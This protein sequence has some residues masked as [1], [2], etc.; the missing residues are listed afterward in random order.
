MRALRVRRDVAE[1]VDREHRRRDLRP[2]D[3][4]V[5]NVDAHE[6]RRLERRPELLDRHTGSEMRG[7]RREDVARVKGARDVGQAVAL[8]DEL[9]RDV[10]LELLRREDQQAVVGADEHA[11]VNGAHGDRAAFAADARIDDREVHAD[12]HVDGRVAQHERALEHRL[13]LDAVRD[14]DHARVRRDAARSRRGRCRR[15]R[16]A[17]RSPSGR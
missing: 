9:V 11:P 6:L 5:R 8:V 14:V 12:R 2:A 15:S 4:R 1:A 7:R 16:P 13:R 3:L 10:D 17:G